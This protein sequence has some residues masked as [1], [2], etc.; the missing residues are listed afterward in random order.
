[1]S[2]STKEK[3]FI[4]MMPYLRPDFPP[5]GLAILKGVFETYGIQC[6]TYDFNLEV[7]KFFTVKETEQLE[8]FCLDEIYIDK[9]IIKKM[10][11]FFRHCIKKF[12]LPFRPTTIGLSLFSFFMQRTTELFCLE[13]RAIMPGVDIFLGGSGVTKFLNKGQTDDW[14]KKIIAHGIAD[15]IIIGEGEQAVIDYIQ[16]KTK[17]VSIIPQIQDL[18]RNAS[19]PNFDDIPIQEYNNKF[20]KDFNLD[21]I[22]VPITGSRGCV[23][24]CSFCNVES[25]WPNYVWK[26]AKQIVDEIETFVKKSKVKNFKF[27]DSLINGSNKQWREMNREIIDRKLDINYTGQFIAKPMG[28][29]TQEDYDLAKKAGC[30]KLWIGIE[31][32]SELV[33]NHMKKKFDNESLYDMI[34][35]L[36]VRNIKQEWML[37][38]GYPTETDWDFEQT[39]NLIRKFEK[40]NDRISLSFVSFVLLPDSPIAWND[41]YKDL[42][43]KSERQENGSIVNY[44]ICEHNPTLN[45]DKRL[46]RFTIARQLGMDLGFSGVNNDNFKKRITDY[47]TKKIHDTQ[48]LS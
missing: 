28:Q 2:K 8:K 12:I 18:S 40:Y 14:P 46:E 19:M 36:C 44:W 22:I 39:L 37:I 35:N 7:N 3:V 43:F 10:R 25:L 9:H 27:T 20:S 15:H 4:G 41:K 42:V 11:L 31:S 17:G 30:S 13:L 16:H 26:P 38:T 1:M 33:R 21:G 6:K 48:I 29:T 47:N 45:F 23:R 24:Q 34:E 32:G 5:L